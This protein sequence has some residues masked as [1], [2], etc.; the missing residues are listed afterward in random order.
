VSNHLPRDISLCLFRVTQEALHNAVK[1]SGASHFAVHLF[2]AGNDIRLEIRDSGRGFE[3]QEVVKDVGLGF[4]SMRERLHLVS[5]T[6]SI[7]SKPSEGTRIVARVP[8]RA[9]NGEASASSSIR[10]IVSPAEPI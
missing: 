2:S 5:G 10:G 8:W 9:S 1:Y 4:V 3:V 7:E 6:L